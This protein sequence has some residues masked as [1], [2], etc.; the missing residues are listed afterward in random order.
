MTSIAFY[1]TA[2]RNFSFKS[3]ER[4]HLLQ[5]NFEERRLDWA[6]IVCP[7]TDNLKAKLHPASGTMGLR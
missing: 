6:K 3:P 1:R 7:I 4:R 5:F 2:S